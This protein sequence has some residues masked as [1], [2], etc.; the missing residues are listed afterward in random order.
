MLSDTDGKAGMEILLQDLRFAVRTVTRRPGFAA[1]ALL[2]LTLGI[3]AATAIFS[4]VNGV[5]LRPL[6]FPDAGELVVLWNT[7][8]ERGQ[9]EYRIAGT[10]FFELERSATSFQG[11]ALVAGA[12]ASLTGED[13]PPMRAEGAAVSA[14]LFEVLGV[15]PLLGRSFLPEEN[16]GDHRVVILSHALWQGRFGGDPEI[17]DKRITMDGNDVQVIGVMPGVSLPV[18][19]GTLRL[20]GPE[21]PTYW[22]PLDFRLDWVSEI[23]AHVMSV[24]ARLRPGVTLDQARAEMSAMARSMGEA[25]GRSTEGILVRPLREQIVGDVRR[26]LVILLGAVGLLL[27][28][29]CGNLA[30][31]LLAR[32]TERERELAVRTALGAG[33]RRLVRQVFTEILL[34]G[35]VGGSLGLLL[36]RWG[37]KGLLALVPTTLPRQSEIGVDGTVL[38]FTLT[39]VL[40]ATLAAGLFPSLRMAGRD[41][42]R[43]LR[44]GGR[45]GTAGRERNRAN[46]SIVAFQF[47]LATLLLVGA[48]LL[49]RS[50]QALRSVDPGFRS[51]RVLTA[52]LILPPSRYAEAEQILAFYDELEEGL[53]ALPGVTSVVFSMDHPL[54]TSW[55]NG[56]G[57]LDQPPPREGEGPIGFFRPV[58]EDYFRTYGIPVLEGRSFDSRDRMGEPGVMAVNESFVKKYFPGGHALGQRIRFQVGQ[59]VWGP[60]AP[61]VFEVVGVVGDVRFNGFRAP[62]EPAFYIPLRQFPYQAVKVQVKTPGDPRQLADAIRSRIW[63]LDPDLPITD[64]R[65]MDRIVEDAVAQDRFNTLLLGAFALAA[66]TLAAAGIYGVLSYMV[67]Q[68][69]P[70][71]GVRLALGA[72]PAAVLRMVVRDGA[73]VAGIGMAGG[74]AA[75]AVLAPSLATLL[76][77]VP[78]RDPA[79]FLGVALILGNAALASAFVPAW[80]AARTDPMEALKGE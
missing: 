80:R 11:M 55:W 53:E 71:L 23:R 32:A 14:G 15:R 20:P 62:N 9:D 72:A 26:N 57:L 45:G 16:E 44:A 43:G 47:G 29:A 7:N 35:L 48:G 24:V 37:T 25:R 52:Q 4:V 30:N 6:P 46:R 19:G 21:V 69:E 36:A 22:T 59:A 28:M 40:L 68:R 75:A 67:A 2:T 1:V 27:L 41:P 17:L 39:A 66:L 79:V 50:F 78:P 64:L 33:R 54:Q 38:L 74:L 10:D 77:G 61:L 63:R 31:L 12:T 65:T 60:G 18:S 49:T 56:V 58:S 34:L 42:D 70:E 3:G 13:L 8:P 51:E 76:F 5:L 73:A